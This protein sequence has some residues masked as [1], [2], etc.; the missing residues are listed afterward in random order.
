MVQDTRHGQGLGS[1]RDKTLVVKTTSRARGVFTIM[2]REY[3]VGDNSLNFVFKADSAPASKDHLAF[4]SL[5]QIAVQLVII[6]KDKNKNTVDMA[7]AS[8]ASLMRTIESL[9]TSNSPMRSLFC[10]HREEFC[11]LHKKVSSLEVFVF[12]GSICQ[13]L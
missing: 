9:L 6:A 2:E 13:E 12:A 5:L 7:P 1:G 11:A 4:A 3:N 8:V 10:D